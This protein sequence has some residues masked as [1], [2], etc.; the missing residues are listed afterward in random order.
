MERLDSILAIFGISLCFLLIHVWNR[1]ASTSEDRVQP[2]TWVVLYFF[3]L[4]FSVLKDGILHQGGVL[5]IDHI[6]AITEPSLGFGF[7]FIFAKSFLD[8]RSL[9]VQLTFMI[10]LSGILFPELRDYILANGGWDGGAYHIVLAVMVW[11]GIVFLSS[12]KEE[13]YSNEK[14]KI[15]E[16]FSWIFGLLHIHFLQPSIITLDRMD[17]VI[18][19]MGSFWSMGVGGVTAWLVYKLI[20]RQDYE[21]WY[22][23]LGIWAG[24]AAFSSL[25]PN[26]SIWLVF[27]LSLLAGVMPALFFP[28][29]NQFTKS[30]PTSIILGGA[31]W[32]GL[33]GYL[34][35]PIVDGM[36]PLNYDQL[37]LVGEKF[38]FILIIF[39]VVS[40]VGLLGIGLGIVLDKV[41]QTRA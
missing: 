1:T 23:I 2:G 3:N 38:Y 21:E 18:S 28:Y 9:S 32:G 39:T 34:S 10:L 30:S 20:G 6:S 15:L 22:I 8:K 33:L 27:I 40:L 31:G 7:F 35:S 36:N 16:W 13:T 26:T 41:N 12:S 19:F 29:I 14:L 4:I 37:S 24:Y 25:S 5:R 17:I 11:L